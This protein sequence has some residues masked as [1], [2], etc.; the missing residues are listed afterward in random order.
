MIVG[1]GNPS[2]EKLVNHVIAR[3]EAISAHA[4]QLNEV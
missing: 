1:K 3:N 4:N 2:V